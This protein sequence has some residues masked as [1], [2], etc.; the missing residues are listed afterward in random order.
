MRRAARLAL[1]V[2]SGCALLLGGAVLGLCLAVIVL[3]VR[4]QD[5]LDGE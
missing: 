1:A 4:A 5:W 2:I 3:T